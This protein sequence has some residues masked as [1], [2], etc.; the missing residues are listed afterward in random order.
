MQTR[1]SFQKGLVQRGQNGVRGWNYLLFRHE[2]KPSGTVLR[3]KDASPSGNTAVAGKKSG[4][5]EY[6]M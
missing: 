5:S 4:V 3:T 1:K 2:F 6:G